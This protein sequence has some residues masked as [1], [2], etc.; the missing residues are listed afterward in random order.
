MK[1]EFRDYLIPLIAMTF[2]TLGMYGVVILKGEWQFL[3]IGFIFIL[4]I[5]YQFDKY[6]SESYAIYSFIILISIFTFTFLYVNKVRNSSVEKI[7]IQGEVSTVYSNSKSLTFKLKEYPDISFKTYDNKIR[8]FFHGYI[9]GK[10][11]ERI[12][13]IIGKKAK[14]TVFKSH[15][16][17][18][19]KPFIKFLKNLRFPLE[20]DIESFEI[21]E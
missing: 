3:L 9:L 15:L 13:V 7:T 10:N 6:I 12:P 4:G 21:I 11:Y 18:C 14:I 8:S 1:K 2:V 19:R 5:S 17:W 16:E 20:V